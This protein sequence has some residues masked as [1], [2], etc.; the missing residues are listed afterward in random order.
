[1]TIVFLIMSPLGGVPVNVWSQDAMDS[2]ES[3]EAEP[4]ATEAETAES[5]LEPAEEAVIP[6]M[7]AT[8]EA[9][10]A[11]APA[12]KEEDAGAID[13]KESREMVLLRGELATLKVYSLTRLSISDPNIADVASADADKLLIIGKALGQTVFFIWDEYGKRTI[14]VRVQEEDQALIK[15]RVEKL[16]KSAKIE[17][18]T[19]EENAYEG[20]LMISGELSKEKFS[21]YST[22]VGPFGDRIINLVK[23][24]LSEDLVQID[25]QVAELNT[26]LQKSS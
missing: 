12:K 7:P 6:D 8:D 1:M 5:Y 23:E 11:E 14:V 19:F 17:G 2:M 9:A 25:M 18:L 26:T 20:K 13:S 22:I 4:M 24:E 21:V 16:L 15:S 10:E 3:Y